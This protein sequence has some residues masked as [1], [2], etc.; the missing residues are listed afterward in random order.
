[1][2]APP[3]AARRLV[4][5]AT[6]RP[7]PA[8]DR[9]LV[10]RILGLLLAAAGGVLFWS[11]PTA[12]GGSSREPRGSGPTLALEDT[13]RAAA[14]GQV[15]EILVTAPRQ[16]LDEILRH[17]QEGE[18]HRDSLIQDQAYTLLLRLTGR[19]EGGGGST[20]PELYLETADRIYQKR[21][22]RSR[23]VHLK[24][25]SRWKKDRNDDEP[26]R[27]N[28][29]PDMSE[30]FVAFAFD[31]ALRARFIF[32]IED[33]KLVGDHV[34][35]IL[36]FRPRSDIDLLPA[37]RAWVDT[38]DFVILREEFSYRDRSPAPLF[39]QSIDSCVLERTLVDQR[40][41]VVSRVLARVTVT[42]PV[43]WMGRLSRQKI[44]KVLDLALA[45]EEWI[46]NGGM[47]DSLFSGPK[48]A[49]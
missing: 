41:W 43:R 13:L 34:V 47:P 48:A 37:G 49:R 32:T 3:A 11:I 27:V 45:R 31:P 8:R 2:N 44:P 1:M 25:W 38:N 20:R 7:A 4:P 15:P 19:E 40:Y 39:L 42:D 6:R 12:R 22:S 46:V 21:P 30:Q 36:G 10:A 18:A 28:A 33:R 16:S 17:V 9:V 23:T 24:E 29:G 26:V 14:A 5:G 35:Y